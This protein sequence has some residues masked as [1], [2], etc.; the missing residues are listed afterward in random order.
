V[1][2][3]ESFAA[4]WLDKESQKEN[5]Y[6]LLMLQ[7]GEKGCQAS[8]VLPELKQE[9]KTELEPRPATFAKQNKI[10]D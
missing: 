6:R 4:S 1:V 2:L 7:K 3:S 8:I 10:R 9:L 5:A